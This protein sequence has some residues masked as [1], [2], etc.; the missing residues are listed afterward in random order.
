MQRYFLTTTW[1]QR[2]LTHSLYSLCKYRHT[3]TKQSTPNKTE[4]IVQRIS[5]SIKQIQK[6]LNELYSESGVYCT[7]NGHQ[8]PYS[9]LYPLNRGATQATSSFMS[10]EKRSYSSLDSQAQGN[11]F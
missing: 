8:L 6:Q 2:H 1:F 3:E 10:T 4:L 11:P 9:V 7:Q 5:S